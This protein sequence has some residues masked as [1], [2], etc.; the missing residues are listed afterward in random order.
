M[1][2]RRVWG[3]RVWGKE[4]VGGGEGQEGEEEVKGELRG[5]K[6]CMCA[7]MCVMGVSL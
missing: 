1:W 2:G 6:V 5:E 7:R 4:G 3:R